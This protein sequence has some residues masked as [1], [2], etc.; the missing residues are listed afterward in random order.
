MVEIPQWI[1]CH[2]GYHDAELAG[3]LDRVDY[4]IGYGFW[5]CSACGKS[6][7]GFAPPVCD[8]GEL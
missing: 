4:E 7:K 6:W 8:S 1:K 2:F 3:A 5:E